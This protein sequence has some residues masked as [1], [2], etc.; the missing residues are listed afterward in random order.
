MN[1]SRHERERVDSDAVVKWRL[2]YFA[3]MAFRQVSKGCTICGIPRTRV[4]GG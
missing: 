3:C 4:A 2:F 1:D